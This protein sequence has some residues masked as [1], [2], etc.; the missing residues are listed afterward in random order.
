MKILTY[1][2]KLD[3]MRS[4]MW[5]YRIPPEHCLEVL[6]GTRERAGHYTES[7]LFRKLV[8]SFPFHTLIRILPEKRILEL[9]TE[10]ILKRLRSKALSKRYEFIRTRLQRNLSNPGPGF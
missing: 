10:E 4:L 1:E 8:E 7:T 9:L 6:E 3:L 5:D 2:E